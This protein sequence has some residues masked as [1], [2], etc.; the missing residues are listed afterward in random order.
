[1]LLMRKSAGDRN[2]GD[3][4][5]LQTQF[6]RPLYATVDQMLIRRRAT[7]PA[8]L[9]GKTDRSELGDLGKIGH[10]DR[11]LQMVLDKVANGSQLIRRQRSH[12]RV[13]ARSDP[14]RMVS[15]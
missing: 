2:F 5:R 15:D 12:V 11:M 8:E 7:S 9:A 10:P 6:L 14:R 3:R 1:M 4:H 13:I